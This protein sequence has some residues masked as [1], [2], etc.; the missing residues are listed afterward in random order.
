MIY[1]DNNYKVKLFAVVSVMWSGLSPAANRSHIFEYINSKPNAYC[2]QSNSG[3]V[4]LAVHTLCRIA[5]KL[6]KKIIN[7]QK[8]KHINNV[9]TP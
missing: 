3:D 8:K 5:F 4:D 1:D 7:L 2:R 9:S 6:R